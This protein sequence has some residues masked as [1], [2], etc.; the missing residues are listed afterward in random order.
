MGDDLLGLLILAKKNLPGVKITFREHPLAILEEKT[1]LKDVLRSDYGSKNQI[2]FEKNKKIVSCIRG[3]GT[4]GYYEIW[5][6]EPFAIHSPERFDN[7]KDVIK[8]IR[9]ILSSRTITKA[10][11]A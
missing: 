5:R 7:P 6:I 11:T 2:L 4:H 9:A 3:I 1:G 10:A 8:R